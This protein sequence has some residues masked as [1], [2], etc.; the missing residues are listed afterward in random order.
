[1]FL[2]D[3]HHSKVEKE[4]SNFQYYQLESNF[5]TR[6][7]L[8]FDEKANALGQRC[9]LFP[10]QVNSLTRMQL[11][12]HAHSNSQ[13]SFHF[14]Q[15]KSCLDG[16]ITKVF[17]KEQELVVSQLTLNRQKHRSA[18][19]SRIFGK[20]FAFGCSGSNQAVFVTSKSWF[21]RKIS[22]F[23]KKNYISF[24][25][26]VNDLKIN[27]CP[28]FDKKTA[29]YG[30]FVGNFCV[31]C[32]VQ[33]EMWKNLKCNGMSPSWKAKNHWKTATKYRVG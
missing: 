29:F 11:E 31:F 33:E 14:W 13:L 21:D 25:G 17:A 10:Q 4:F 32:K 1:M 20:N 23:F 22:R 16:R 30:H 12:K 24:L 6:L 19:M 7:T 28:I 27:R 2:S 5:F 3:K 15:L 18:L 26:W 8:R 9:L